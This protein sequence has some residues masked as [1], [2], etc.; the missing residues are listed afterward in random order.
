MDDKIYFIGEVFWNVT[1]KPPLVVLQ[2]T[3][4]L[5][6]VPQKAV[7]TECC[8]MGQLVK[9][10]TAVVTPRQ[11]AA[12]EGVARYLAATTICHCFLFS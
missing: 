6:L 11:P 2:L 4:C 3:Q 8:H 10:Q 5:G 9:I 1:H 12:L 7:S